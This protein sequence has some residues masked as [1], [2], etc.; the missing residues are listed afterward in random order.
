MSDLETKLTDELKAATERLAKAKDLL[1]EIVVPE[2]EDSGLIWKSWESPTHPETLASGQT[3]QVYDHEHFSE[4]GDALVELWRVLSG[5]PEEPN[6]PASE[7]VWIDHDGKSEPVASD[8]LVSVRCRCGFVF[9]GTGF[10]GWVW[11]GTDRDILAYRE[12][13]DG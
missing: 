2:G 7:P 6:Q 13:T 1:E 10:N 8:R 11:R 5:Q 4:L 9:N 3:I 12:L